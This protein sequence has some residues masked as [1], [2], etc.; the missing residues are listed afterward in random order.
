MEF[1]EVCVAIGDY[2]ECMSGSVLIAA[3]VFECLIYF[4]IFIFG[5]KFVDWFR[6]ELKREK[7]GRKKI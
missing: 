7:N 2:N 6:R 4:F 5:V 1:D 3:V